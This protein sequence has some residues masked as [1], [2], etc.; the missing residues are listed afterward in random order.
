[1]LDVG[2]LVKEHH[3]IDTT[4]FQGSLS[5]W[6]TAAAEKGVIKANILAD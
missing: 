5:P 1:M 3:G 4:I 2:T 6:S